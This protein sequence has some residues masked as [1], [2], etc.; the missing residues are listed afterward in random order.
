MSKFERHIKPHF[1]E[2][3]QKKYVY[4]KSCAH[5]SGPDH[6]IARILDAVTDAKALSAMPVDKFTELFVKP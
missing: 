4:P 2:A 3:H 5:R 6:L 1:E